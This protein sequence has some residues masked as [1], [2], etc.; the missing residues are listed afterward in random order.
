MLNELREKSFLWKIGRKFK[1][2]LKKM[3][4]RKITKYNLRIVKLIYRNLARRYGMSVQAVY[5]CLP[6]TVEIDK[7][8]EGAYGLCQAGPYVEKRLFRKKKKYRKSTI[9]LNG[10]D[11]TTTTFI[12]EFG[13]YLRFLIAQI[14]YHRNRKAVEDFRNVTDLVRSRV[15]VAKNK[16]DNYFTRGE[17]TVD[18]EENFAKS[19]EQYLKD[20][21]A[22]DKKHKK[23]FEDF[24]KF[25]FDDMHRRSEKRKYEFYEDLEV[26][27]TPERRQFFDELIIGK[28]MV[29]L[30]KS[31]QITNII[32]T[33]LEIYIYIAVFLIVIKLLDKYVINIY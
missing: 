7:D 20:G 2:P 4:S 9:V 27:I 21:I 3:Y 28:K 5:G 6:L 17:F 24:R 32:I 31:T 12:H 19:W 16:H 11:V 26:K 15:D 33:I 1:K 14:A 25:I 30:N 13:H 29:K 10:N 8:M 18:E 23:L 22:P